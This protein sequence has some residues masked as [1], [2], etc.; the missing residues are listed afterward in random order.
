MAENAVGYTQ[1]KRKPSGLEFMLTMPS[2]SVGTVGGGTRLPQQQQN[3]KL[4]KCHDGD[5]SAAKLAEIICASALCL[6]ISLMAAI[7]S[8]KWV[9]SHMRYGR[10]KL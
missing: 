4:L 2:I 7:V 6:E 9:D 1:I 3:L 10:S 8:E 5:H